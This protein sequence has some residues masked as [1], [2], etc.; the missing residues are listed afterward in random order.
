MYNSLI[1]NSLQSCTAI[2]IVQF[3]D[4]S[5]PLRSLMPISPHFHP[6]PKTTIN[7]PSVSIDLLFLDISYRWAHTKCGLLC[8]ASL[9]QHHFWRFIH[10]V[11]CVSILFLNPFIS[12]PW[13]PTSAQYIVE[14]KEPHT[15]TRGPSK[16][17]GAAHQINSSQPQAAVDEASIPM[18]AVHDVSVAIC[19]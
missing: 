15:M 10:V 18:P 19:F 9:T 4:V 16:M 11:A 14:A 1:Y 13:Y 7:L 3:G 12:Y 17:R 8:L 6:Q 2:T 5:I